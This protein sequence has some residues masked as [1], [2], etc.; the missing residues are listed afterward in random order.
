[1]HSSGLPPWH[2][3][4]A[5]NRE[6]WLGLLTASWGTPVCSSLE[7]WPPCAKRFLRCCWMPSSAAPGELFQP[8]SCRRS[9]L[10]CRALQGRRDTSYA[11][12]I[13]SEMAPVVATT[14]NGI[15]ADV[16]LIGHEGV[17]GSLQLPGS[18]AVASTCFI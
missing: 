7:R 16:G 3:L 14:S 8:S 4:L 17:T 18:I 10:R 1:L 13:S 9:S 5:I 2:I 11:F 15:T 12:F 6:H